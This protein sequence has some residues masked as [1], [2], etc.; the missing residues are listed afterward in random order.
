MSPNIRGL[1]IVG[2]EERVALYAD[3]M[4]LFFNDADPSLQGA[5][6]LMNVYFVVTG[7]KVNWAKYLL[8]AIDTWA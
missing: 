2:L 1:R 6:N 8:L 4:L 5:L 7:L 3:Y